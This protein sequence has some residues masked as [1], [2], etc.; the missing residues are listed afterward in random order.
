MLWAYLK[1]VIKD[2][3]ERDSIL[4]EWSIFVKEYY[5]GYNKMEQERR[6]K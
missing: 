5:E 6:I 2:L 3:K 4:R 1:R